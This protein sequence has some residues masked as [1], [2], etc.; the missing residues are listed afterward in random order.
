[1]DAPIGGRLVGSVEIDHAIFNQIE[2]KQLNT[3]EIEY[4]RGWLGFPWKKSL[5]FSLRGPKGKDG[6]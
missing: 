2:N 1:L 3:A 6:L 4:G 5:G